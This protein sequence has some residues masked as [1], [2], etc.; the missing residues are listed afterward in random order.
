MAQGQLAA[1]K[2]EEAQAVAQKDAIEVVKHEV[3]KAWS[4][5][6]GGGRYRFLVREGELKDLVGELP[7]EIR[8]TLPSDPGE[9]FPDTGRHTF[10]F[11]DYELHL[12]NGAYS[13]YLWED[14]NF[15][16]DTVLLTNRW[17][18]S[19]VGVN[20]AAASTEGIQARLNQLYAERSH[21]QT[22][23]ARMQEAE[24]AE[25]QLEVQVR[26]AEIQ[27]EALRD[28]L[29]DEELQVIRRQ[30]EQARAGLEAL[31]RQREM[32]TLTSPI[33]GTVSELL[34]VPGEVAAQGAT[35][36]RIADL[37]A[38]T[39]TVY[40]PETRLGDLHIGQEVGIQVDSF[41]DRVFTGEIVRIADQAEFTPRNIST[42]EERVNLVFAVDIALRGAGGALR[43]GMPVDATFSTA[44]AAFRTIS[45]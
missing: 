7:E 21:P 17:W 6:D 38:L 18:K 5:F 4:Q 26:M 43:P 24:S 8:E 33:S 20:A 23:I 36:M 22:W 19:W 30:V 29:S 3:D 28:G 14:V 35:V 40:V 11:K 31:R 32:L 15:G 37:D 39:L 16:L 10:E 41:P 13:L 25:A 44:G 1:A 45:P 34:M 12:D 9:S 42:Q 2:H 27:L